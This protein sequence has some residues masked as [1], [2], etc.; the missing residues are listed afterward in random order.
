MNKGILSAVLKNRQKVKE[1][2]F[3]TPTVTAGVRGTTLLLNVESEKRTYTCLCHGK[4][5]LLPADKSDKALI[6]AYHHNANYYEQLGSR[7]QISKSEMKYH[8]D[9]QQEALAQAIGETI[10]W[11]KAN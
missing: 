1:F 11:S 6:E 8:D 3:E 4:L 5:R 7:I 9:S 10:N 2:R